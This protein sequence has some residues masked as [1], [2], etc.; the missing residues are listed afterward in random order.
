[1]QSWGFSLLELIRDPQGESYRFRAEIRH[2]ESDTNGEVGL[3][4]AHRGYPSAQGRVHQFLQVSFNDIQIL[5]RPLRPIPGF[6]AD[7]PPLPN[8]VCLSPNLYAEG[9]ALGRWSR[10]LPG[11]S[12]G[13]PPAGRGQTSWR[14]LLVEVTPERIRARWGE[15]KWIGTLTSNE[16]SDSFR[17]EKRELLIRM[18]DEGCVLDLHEQVK[19][20]GGLGLSVHRGSASFRNVVVEPF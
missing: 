18:P 4:F 12:A 10:R 15:D 14:N 16:V 11:R 17:N 7:R 2:D 8:S 6:P 19:N 1:L 3:Y 9:G 13:F 5:G 20:R